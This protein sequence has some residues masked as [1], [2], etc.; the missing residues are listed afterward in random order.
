[1]HVR[2]VSEIIQSDE[3]S[4]FLLLIPNE[5]GTVFKRLERLEELEM[6]YSQPERK[7]FR[8]QVIRSTYVQRDS[9]RIRSIET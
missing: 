2:K 1:M 3:P 6:Q 8:V 4:N 5:F 7:Q 9:H